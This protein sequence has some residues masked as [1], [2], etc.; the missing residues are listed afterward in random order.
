MVAVYSEGQCEG[1]AA[2]HLRVQ[3]DTAHGPSSLYPHAYCRVRLDAAAG[4]PGILGIYYNQTVTWKLKL[5]R[6]P[7]QP[8][9]LVVLF[10]KRVLAVL[11]DD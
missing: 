5:L 7:V 11:I 6:I 3:H 9:R 1:Q 8:N 2:P 10:S 4:I